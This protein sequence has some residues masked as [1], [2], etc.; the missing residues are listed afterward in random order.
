MEKIKKA[1]HL[2]YRKI[3]GIFFVVDS[4]SSVLHELS[5]TASF[6][7][8]R[9]NGKNSE[10]DLSEILSGE[11]LVTPEQAKRDVSEFVEELKKAKLLE[12]L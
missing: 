9:I 6:L 11:F 7:W 10:E 12:I 5:E 2:A 1:K 8:E 3:G 4:R